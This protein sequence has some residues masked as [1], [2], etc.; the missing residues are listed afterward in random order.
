M[1]R[2]AWRGHS[3]LLVQ[4][5]VRLRGLVLSCL[6]LSF[7]YSSLHSAAP[8]VSVLGSV[9]EVGGYTFYTM[10]PST[11]HPGHWG[12]AVT[13]C[14]RDAVDHVVIVVAEFVRP[15]TFPPPSPQFPPLSVPVLWSEA[16]DVPLIESDMRLV[17]CVPQVSWGSGWFV[18]SV[19][20]LRMPSRVATLTLFNANT[21]EVI[22]HGAVCR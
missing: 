3:L 7:L 11:H 6:I 20:R 5:V 21:S 13:T 14:Y 10:K 8:D 15:T 16:L 12:Y 18:Y 9:G 19:Y 4:G 17:H 22:Y 2:P 1:G